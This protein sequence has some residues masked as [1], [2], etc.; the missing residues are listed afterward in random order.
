MQSISLMVWLWFLL[1]VGYQSRSFEQAW[2]L[3]EPAAAGG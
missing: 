3:T 2:K 1:G